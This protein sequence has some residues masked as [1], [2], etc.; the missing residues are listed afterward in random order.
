MIESDIHRVINL[1]E[2]HRASAKLQREMGGDG[3]MNELLA[4]EHDNNA[5]ALDAVLNRAMATEEQ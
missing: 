2:W 4:N 5:N 1:I 3:R